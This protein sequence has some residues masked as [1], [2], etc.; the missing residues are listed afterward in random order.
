MEDC[1]NQD[2][3]EFRISRKEDCLNQDLPDFRIDRIFNRK[4]HRD[5][6]RK[7]RKELSESG[8]TRF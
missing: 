7:E 6:K 3:R 1:L 8:F 2:L 5:K 4:G